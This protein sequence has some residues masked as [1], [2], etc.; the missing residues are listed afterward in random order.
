MKCWKSDQKQFETSLSHGSVLSLGSSVKG[1]PL[2]VES[3]ART[4]HV[5]TSDSFFGSPVRSL[6]EFVHDSELL[7]SRSSRKVNTGTLSHVHVVD[8]GVS[9]WVSIVVVKHGLRSSLGLERFDVGAS[10]CAQVLK[11]GH[12]FNLLNSVLNLLVSSVVK[13]STGSLSS[14]VLNHSSESQV[15][16]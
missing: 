10:R 11:S 4:V 5:T 14:P 9:K 6:L 2:V 12:G 8:V 16:E 1:S 15:L 7:L 3:C 13:E